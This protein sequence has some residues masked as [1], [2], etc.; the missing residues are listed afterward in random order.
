MKDIHA[1]AHSQPAASIP[2]M[3]K[4]AG[5]LIVE[6]NPE[7]TPLTDFATDVF[8]QGKS[9]E[10]LPALRETIEKLKKG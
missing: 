2:L 8:L 10:I 9:G 7:E 3:A 6:I 1:P 5:A 4:Q